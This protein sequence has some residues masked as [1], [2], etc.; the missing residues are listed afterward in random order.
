M[1]VSERRQ[2][3]WPGEEHGLPGPKGALC[4][5]QHGDAIADPSCLELETHPPSKHDVT[6]VPSGVPHVTLP[7]ADRGLPAPQTSWGEEEGGCRCRQLDLGP[8][9]LPAVPLHTQL[10]RS[11]GRHHARV[12]ARA[13][14]HPLQTPPDQPDFDLM[15]AE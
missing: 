9:G 10:L 4:P 7:P 14:T 2:G 8:A 15:L 12:Y 5:G 11:G 1:T 3:P 13:D 6:A